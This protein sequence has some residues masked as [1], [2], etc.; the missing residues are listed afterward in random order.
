MVPANLRSPTSHPKVNALV[1]EM[2]ALC[3]PDAIH[4][5]DGSEQENAEPRRERKIID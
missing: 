1:E 3:E 2:A 4:W 5:C